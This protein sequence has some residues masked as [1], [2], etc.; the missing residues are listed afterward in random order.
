MTLFEAPVSMRKRLEERESVM[1]VR[2]SPAP[3]VLMRH[4][5]IRRFL[6]CRSRVADT[7]ELCRRNVDGR[8]SRDE[9][10]E[11]GGGKGWESGGGRCWR[12]EQK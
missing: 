7:F 2:W 1:K 10:K 5:Q 12:A 9:G 4:R 6:A 8:S 3:T 11:T